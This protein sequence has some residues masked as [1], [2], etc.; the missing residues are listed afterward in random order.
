MSLGVKAW[1]A[2]AVGVIGYN[3][4]TREGETFSETVDRAVEAYPLLT[5]LVI[6][7]FAVHLGNL[8]SPRVDVIH[9]GFVGARVVIHRRTV[10][11]Q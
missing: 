4:F 2:L 5:R 6:A 8:V 3:L 10:T 1:I 9:L 11:A 7:A